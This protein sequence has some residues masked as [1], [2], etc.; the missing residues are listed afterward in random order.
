VGT[1]MMSFV[2]A[3]GLANLQESDVE[4]VIVYLRN[5]NTQ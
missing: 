3:R 4:D 1:A 2:G 5:Q